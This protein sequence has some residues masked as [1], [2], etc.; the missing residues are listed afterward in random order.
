[1]SSRA[2]DLRM[3]KVE[4]NR[5]NGVAIALPK[6]VGKGIESWEQF[7]VGFFVSKRHI[8]W[9]VRRFLE[10]RWHLKEP[11]DMKLKGSLF[12]IKLASVEK[13]NKILE[14]G[15]ISI[16]GRIFVL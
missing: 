6:M 9:T 3:R 11:L 14:S 8:F 15:P 1:M 12:F 10:N 4:V 7:I 2:G 13:R 5:V 16:F